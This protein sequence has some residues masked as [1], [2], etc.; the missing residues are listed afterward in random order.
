MGLAV[1]VGTLASALEQ[2]D[3]DTVTILRRD[4]K[5][6]NRLLEAEGLPAFTEPE[7]LPPIKD[8]P[9][10]KWDRGLQ[11]GMWL[12]NVPYSW[13]GHMQRAIAFARQAPPG[14]KFTPMPADWE[15]SED[16]WITEE[17][18]ANESHILCHSSTE[19][20]FVPIDFPEPIHDDGSR[21]TGE[22]L[23]SSQHAS[24]E[25]VE[26]APLLGI[27]LR[28]GKLSDKAAAIIAEE[29]EGSHPYWIKRHV[30]LLLFDR[31]RQSIEFGTAVVFE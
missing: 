29:Q 7:S 1:S 13:F 24:Q 8:R 5:Q 4:F 22:I 3:T 30:W 19:G 11:R 26:T 14:E 2:G 12:S 15:F 31:F 6:I 16:P 27:S 23:G 25:L 28:S 10:L 9:G 18:F 17:M 21:L 20:Y